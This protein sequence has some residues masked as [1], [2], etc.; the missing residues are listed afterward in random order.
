MFLWFNWYYIDD[1]ERWKEVYAESGED[2]FL[3]SIRD[4][5]GKY[6]RGVRSPFCDIK[7]ELLV[8]KMFCDV[9]ERPIRK[10]GLDYAVFHI[11][12]IIEEINKRLRGKI[13]IKENCYKIKSPL[14]LTIFLDNKDVLDYGYPQNRKC[15]I[16]RDI[17]L[18]L[19]IFWYFEKSFLG[20]E[21]KFDNLKYEYFKFTVSKIQRFVNGRIKEFFRYGYNT[22]LQ[23]E[24]T[25][26]P[27]S[28]EKTSTIEDIDKEESK[29][30]KLSLPTRITLLNELGFFKLLEGKGYS[31]T[32]IEKITAKLLNADE[33]NTRGNIN[34]LNPYSGEDLTK[35]TAG[36]EANTI[37]AKRILQDI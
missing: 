20:W 9:G 27:L 15:L 34:A 28:K 33:R 12:E 14:D 29:G 17:V 11:S 19:E 32:Q 4:F 25:I 23:I 30:V 16:S 31:K 7:R 18:N 24:Q 13:D 1:F 10:N 22:R 26:P 5:Y 35:Y 6:K 8:N 2:D 21:F 37:K 3:K 36:N